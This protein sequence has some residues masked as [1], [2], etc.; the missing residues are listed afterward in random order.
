[1]QKT[2]GLFVR[3]EGTEVFSLT[4][5]WVFKGIYTDELTLKRAK[6]A[7]KTDLMVR[8]EGMRATAY[9]VVEL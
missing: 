5:G 2:W 9:K 6:N 1:M 3:F 8:R 7:I 4:N